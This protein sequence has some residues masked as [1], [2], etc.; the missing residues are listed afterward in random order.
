[1]PLTLYLFMCVMSISK[2]ITAIWTY[3]VRIL[4]VGYEPSSDTRHIERD[5]SAI[6]VM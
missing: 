3:L 5:K 2:I 6:R 1:M 4:A